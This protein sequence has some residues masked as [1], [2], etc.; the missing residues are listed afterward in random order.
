MVYQP[1]V[2]LGCRAISLFPT[3]TEPRIYRH[4]SAETIPRDRD[5]RCSLDFAAHMLVRIDEHRNGIDVRLSP[6]LGQGRYGWL[7]GQGVL[8]RTN[9]TRSAKSPAEAGLNDVAVGRSA[10]SRSATR[11]AE[12]YRCRRLLGR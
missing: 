6:D 2:L 11:A 7:A 10:V 3:A 1:T 8:I 5:L 4:P 12:S 9:P